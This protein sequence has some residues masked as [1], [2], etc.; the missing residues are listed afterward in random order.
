MAE[1]EVSIQSSIRGYHAYFKEAT[2]CVGEVL[3]CEIEENNSHDKNAIVVKNE[4]G[5]VVGHV[6]LELSKTLNTFIRNYGELEAECIGTRYNL[7]QGKGLE[8]PVDYRLC[9]NFQYL[10][11]VVKRV[12]NLDRLT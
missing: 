8:I 4:H 2:V 6:P 12:K 9:E 7:G 3:K 11:K 5:T 10:E 1:Y